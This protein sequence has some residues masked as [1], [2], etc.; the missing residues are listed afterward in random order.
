MKFDSIQVLRGLA[1][2]FVVLAHVRHYVESLETNSVDNIF[3]IFNIAFNQGAILFFV[4]S[5]FLMSYLIDIGY[6]NFLSRRL[7]RIYPTYI[8]VATIVLV[9]EEA[10]YKWILHPTVLKAFSLLPFGNV[11]Y[12]MG[13]E[14]TLV[15]EVF[16]Y[17]VCAVFTL[18]I[19]REWFHIFLWGWL[20]VILI[21]A[22]NAAAPQIQM[23]PTFN[24]IFFDL[25]NMYFVGGGLTY[26][27][28][29][30]FPLKNQIIGKILIC[31]GIVYMSGYSVFTQISWFS[32]A[33]L[34]IL[35]F[36]CC[37]V[38]LGA[39]SIKTSSFK[40][41]KQFLMKIG[42]YSYALYLV[43]MPTIL[44]IFLYYKFNI[45]RPIDSTIAL[46]AFFASLG[47]G[48]LV[49]KLDVFIHERTKLYLTKRRQVIAKRA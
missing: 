10:T 13:V 40:K 21:F 26:Y 25:Y 43:H 41:S 1:A 28:Y 31:S 17:F 30:R 19:L 34:F 5:G 16:F 22:Y 15:Y 27:F 38:L 47:L 11:T 35:L 3:M 49:G 24:T 46:I 12:T 2:V 42:D 37:G 44:L 39:L 20:A 8:I 33:Q 6:R 32:K 9:T 14:W 29:K 7:A 4:I 23:H 18:N 45:G 48:W 36:C